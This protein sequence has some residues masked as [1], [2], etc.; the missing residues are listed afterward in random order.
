MR[1]S[2][3]DVTWYEDGGLL[4][5]W[6]GEGRPEDRKCKYCTLEEA[7]QFAWQNN[8]CLYIQPAEQD[9]GLFVDYTE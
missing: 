9:A 8:F 3:T 4:E 1:F 6:T 5:W 7:V 2:T